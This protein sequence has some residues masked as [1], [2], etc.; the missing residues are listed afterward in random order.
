MIKHDEMESVQFLVILF[1]Y[2][3][4]DMKLNNQKG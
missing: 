3:W 1:V 4:Q 2:I